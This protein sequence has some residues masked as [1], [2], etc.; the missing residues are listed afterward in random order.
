[1]AIPSSTTCV[2]NMPEPVHGRPCSLTHPA[3]SSNRS[4]GAGTPLCG[5]GTMSLV[6]FH[7]DHADMVE[8]LDGLDTV[9][10]RK[11]TQLGRYTLGG[12]TYLGK[13]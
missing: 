7:I 13:V 10:T 9:Q 12:S 3:T 2:S 6:L 8:V 1:M 11:V 5:A 4:P